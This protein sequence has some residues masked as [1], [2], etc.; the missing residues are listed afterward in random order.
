MYLCFYFSSVKGEK[1]NETVE[2]YGAAHEARRPSCSVGDEGSG[3]MPNLEE[4][5]K[6]K[7]R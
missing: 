5:S 6:G 7:G 3:N 1:G 4:V 2:V